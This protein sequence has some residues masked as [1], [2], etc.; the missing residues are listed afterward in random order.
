M[1]R[2]RA[3]TPKL[4]ELTP[5]IRKEATQVLDLRREAG[6]SLWRRSSFLKVFQETLSRDNIKNTWVG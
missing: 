2:K 1:L 4:T 6:K 3:E 5:F